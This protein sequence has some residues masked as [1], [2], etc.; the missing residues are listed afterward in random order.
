MILHLTD[1]QM[2]K[3]NVKRKI[4]DRNNWTNW[5]KDKII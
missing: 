4:A 3:T 2:R 1:W 5:F